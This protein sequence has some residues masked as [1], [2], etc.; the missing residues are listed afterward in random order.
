MRVAELVLDPAGMLARR[1]V[2][3]PVGDRADEADHTGLGEPG[4]LI[5]HGAQVTWLSAQLMSMTTGAWSLAPLPLRSSRSIQA[6]STRAA[7]ASEARM[8]SIRSPR[9]L[10][11]ASCW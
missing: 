4:G 9:F 5:G 10:G 2:T 7:S 8:K 1:S 6:W 3:Q 11:N